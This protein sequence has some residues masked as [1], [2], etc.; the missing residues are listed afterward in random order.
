MHYK[1]VQGTMLFKPI[2][3]FCDTLDEKSNTTTGW[4]RNIN[5]GIYY[6]KKHCNDYKTWILAMINVKKIDGSPWFLCVLSVDLGLVVMLQLQ[7]AMTSP[8]KND[9]INQTWW[10]IVASYNLLSQI[11]NV[12]LLVQKAINCWGTNI[13]LGLIVGIWTFWTIV[14]NLA[15]PPLPIKNV[16]ALNRIQIPLVNQN[17]SIMITLSFVHFYHRNHYTKH[18]HKFPKCI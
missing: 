14:G 11:D 9:Q 3:F 16:Q 15:Y 6:I 12:K 8:S 13:F 4:E 2:R 1:I 5:A 10:E 17:Q 7:Q 18:K